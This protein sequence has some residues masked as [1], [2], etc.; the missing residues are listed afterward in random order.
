MR[1]LNSAMTRPKVHCVSRV[2]KIA[3]AIYLETRFGLCKLWELQWP[4]WFQNVN[5]LRR[6]EPDAGSVDEKSSLSPGIGKDILLWYVYSHHLHRRSCRGFE[7]ELD[8]VKN[9]RLFCRL[10]VSLKWRKRQ[11]FSLFGKIYTLFSCLRPIDFLHSL[12][13]VDKKTGVVAEKRFKISREM[14]L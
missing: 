14:M 12:T 13:A 6:F 3:L 9:W 2:L 5:I 8:K 11:I 1:W 4:R 7:E 10:V